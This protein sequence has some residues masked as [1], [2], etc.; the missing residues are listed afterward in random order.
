MDTPK[1]YDEVIKK[2]AVS[3]AKSMQSAGAIWD[4][5]EHEAARAAAE[6]IGLRQMMEALERLREMDQTR[7]ERAVSQM[8]GRTFR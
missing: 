5:N 2:M 8:Y 6:E 7:R 3:I 1:G 4:Y